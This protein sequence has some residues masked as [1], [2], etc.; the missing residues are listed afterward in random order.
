MMN[1]FVGYGG[2][3]WHK[4]CYGID[5]QLE[6]KHETRSLSLTPPYAPTWSWACL[7]QSV[8][9][10]PT[11]PKIAPSFKILNVHCK[12]TGS[13]PYGP[14]AK[15]SYIE[16]S[17]LCVDVRMGRYGKIQPDVGGLTESDSW[18]QVRRILTTTR[19]IGASGLHSCLLLTRSK[20]LRAC[21]WKE[22]RRIQGLRE[23]SIKG[24]DM[25]RG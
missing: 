21:C 12:P 22:L 11:P 4:I 14:V 8:E 20:R 13:N 25:W 16:V 1:I 23:T 6:A 2:P 15:D 17:G 24:E 5:P 3:R 19:Y 18:P 9:Y 10:S 7:N